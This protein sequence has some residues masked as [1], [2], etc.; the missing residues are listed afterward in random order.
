VDGARTRAGVFSSAF[1]DCRGNVTRVRVR[2]PTTALAESKIRRSMDSCVR[3]PHTH[4]IQKFG[5]VVDS[6]ARRV[7]SF[8][9]G[10]RPAA[11]RRS[12]EATDMAEEFEV[13]WEGE[14][15]ASPRE[16]WDAFTRRT[17]GWL[18]DIDY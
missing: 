16:V 1:F 4:R 7:S 11:R 14:L 8:Q 13:T 5:T 17:A 3:G 18:W 9:R 2:R 10:R 12:S 15:P 6:G